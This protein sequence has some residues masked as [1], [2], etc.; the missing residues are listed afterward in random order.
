MKTM[1]NPKN[2]IK[3]YL[4]KRKEEFSMDY[5]EYSLESY[6]EKLLELINKWQLIE[7]GSTS[8]IYFVKHKILNFKSDLNSNLPNNYDNKKRNHRE[9]WLIQKQIINGLKSDFLKVFDKFYE[10]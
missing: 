3:E 9:K 8:E 10:K 7:A 5:S 1:F 4:E 2:E 6:A